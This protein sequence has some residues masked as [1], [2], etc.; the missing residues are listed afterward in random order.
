MDALRCEL[1]HD[2]S[3]AQVTMVQMPALNTPQFGWVKSHLPHKAQPV[4]PIYQPE[5]AAEAIVQAAH[6]PRREFY[7]G[8]S[9]AIAIIGNKF[10][11]GVAD[12]YLTRTGYTS[13]T[14]A[15]ETPNR[16]HNLWEPV[17]GDHGA[18][19]TFDARARAHSCQL[20]ANTPRWLALAGLG[21]AGVLCTALAR[22]RR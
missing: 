1:L 6:H 3:Q 9:T 18:H 8:F 19:G 5:V 16:P 15:P 17:S 22:H 20:W 10:M 11:P 14:E 4:P 12:W 2:G 13:H 21:L 7:V